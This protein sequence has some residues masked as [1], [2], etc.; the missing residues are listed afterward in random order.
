LQAV[1]LPD[2]PLAGWGISLRI[3]VMLID[4]KGDACVSP[5]SVATVIFAAVIL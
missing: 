2:R 5:S 1:N 4:D 3:R